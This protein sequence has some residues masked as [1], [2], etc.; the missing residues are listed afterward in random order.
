MEVY[1]TNIF[2]ILD[3]LCKLKSDLAK[4]RGLKCLLM[5]LLF[6]VLLFFSQCLYF[7]TS[8]VFRLEN[9]IT[10]VPYLIATGRWVFAFCSVVPKFC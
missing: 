10:D 4:E 8:L 7:F 1:E 3:Q 5:S 9:I 2:V 6:F